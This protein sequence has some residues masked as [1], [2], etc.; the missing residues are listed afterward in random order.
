MICPDASSGT[1]ALLELEFAAFTE[2][3]KSAPAHGV[4]DT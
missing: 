3:G 1:E 4:H 2:P